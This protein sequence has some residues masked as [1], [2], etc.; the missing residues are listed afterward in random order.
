MSEKTADGKTTAKA[1][2]EGTALTQAL[3]MLKA[4]GGAAEQRISIEVKG[5]N[6]PIGK[7]EIP[8]PSVA[9]LLSQA[10]NTIISLKYGG[11]SYDLPLKEIDVA[12]LANRVGT[13]SKDVKIII[14]IE[15]VSGTTLSSI[16]AKAKQQGLNPLVPAVDFT[17]TAEAGGGKQVQIN[18]FGT[19]YVTRTLDL[20]KEPDPK[21]T[22]AVLFNP[23][24]GT[25]S[26]VPA[27][28][29]T[30]GGVSKAT[31]RRPGN[32]IYTVVEY[33]KSFEDLKGHWSQADVELLASKLVVNGITDSSFAPQHEITRAEFA[34]L[35]VRALGLT[36]MTLTKFSDV[37]ANDW[38][39]GAIGAASQAGLVDGFENGTFQPAANITRE[40]MAVMMTRAMSVAGKKAD[41]SLLGLSKFSDAASVSGWA[42]DAVAQAVN[43]GIINGVTNDTFVPNAKASRAEAAVMLKRLLQ[44]EQL[45]N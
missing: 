42:K 37:K 17:V 35:L 21:K 24:T 22:T 10:P 30:T 3:D 26:F 7:L 38:F 8:S 28:F 41:G 19:L 45:M 9:D 18:D 12:A 27:T 13:A 6:E 23:V 5:N 4:S 43:A 32:S 15:K 14:S 11:A 25:F 33:F 40:Q 1:V 34:T 20:A 44:Y 39:A 31:V 36:E 16:E 29:S 2:L